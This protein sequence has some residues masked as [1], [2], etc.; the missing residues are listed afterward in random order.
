MLRQAPVRQV[1]PLVFL[2]ACVACNSEGGLDTVADT[3]ADASVW[4]RDADRIA[5]ALPRT[6]GKFVPREAVDPFWTSY[7]TGPV[8]GA[9]CVYADGGRQ[10]L[11]RVE[12]GNIAARSLAALEPKASSEG[13]PP[14]RP[15]RVKGGPAVTHWDAD[16]RESEVTFLVARRYLVQLRVVPATGEG[17]APSLAETFDVAGLQALALEGVKSL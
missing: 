8:F 4:H 10:V 7:R 13:R 17:E 16:G 6:I 9:T 3:G 5:G 1:A 15:I 14:G 12:S 11:V 2:V